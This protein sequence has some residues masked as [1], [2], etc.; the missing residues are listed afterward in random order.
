MPPVVRVL[1][2]SSE[3]RSSRRSSALAPPP[4]RATDGVSLYVLGAS[5]DSSVIRISAASPA[6]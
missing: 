4:S 2:T 6:T 1:W 5:H 3:T